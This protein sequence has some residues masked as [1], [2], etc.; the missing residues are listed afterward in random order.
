MNK[1]VDILGIYRLTSSF[2]SS[3]HGAGVYGQI[4]LQ[5]LYN[6]GTFDLLSY[7]IM[8]E[9]T[10]LM[11]MLF[12]ARLTFTWNEQNRELFIHHRFPFVE[13]MV[14]IEASVERTE[15]DILSDRYARP[16]VRRYAAAV[17]RLI[18]AE[19]RGKFSTLPGA[20]GSVTLN[21]ET[22]R[23]ASA[24]EIEALLTEIENYIVDRP[25]EWG[26]GQTFTFG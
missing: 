19:I 9:Y 3:A 24:T 21:A 2:L 20:G 25:E 4:V 7:H 12:A 17:C 18:L 10:K 11:E 13:R 16:W 6:M 1:I 8:G 5:H 23:Q 14:A 22:L 15:Q 26:I